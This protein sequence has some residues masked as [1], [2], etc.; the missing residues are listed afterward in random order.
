MTDSELYRATE[1]VKDRLYYVVVRAAPPQRSDVHLFTIDDTLN[2]WPFFLDFG[3]LNLGSLYRFS[4]LLKTKL[5]DKA[6]ATKRIYLYSSTHMHKRANAVYLLAAFSLLYL[7]KSPEEAY[8][9]FLNIS[10]PLAPWHD[11]S[12][13]VDTFH[14]STLDVLR[15]IAKARDNNF[16]SFAAFDIDEYEHYERVEVRFVAVHARGYGEPRPG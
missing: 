2:Y 11:A 4:E 5:G 6:L 15:G 13:T 14:L 3:P 7:G 16:F 1:V 9:P 10:P 12:P 8:R